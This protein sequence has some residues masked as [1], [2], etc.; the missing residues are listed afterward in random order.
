M[1]LRFVVGRAGSGKSAWVYG[2]IAAGLS[3][4]GRSVYLVVPEQYTLHTE[5][6]LMT[7]LGA[8]GLMQVRVV[9]P[10]RL[11]EEVFAQVR[12]E[13]AKEIGESGLAMALRA[14]AAAVAGD[15]QAYRAVL[16][17]HGFS[18]EMV[19]LIAECRRFD[20]GPDQIGAAAEHTRGALQAK[21]RDIALLYRQYDAFLQSHR[22]IDGESRFNSFIDNIAGAAFLAGCRFYFDGFDYLSAQNCRMVVALATVGESV[23]LVMDA[24]PAPGEDDELFQAAQRNM[25]RLTALVEPMGMVVER[26]A[27]DGSQRR[28]PMP[29]DV[30]HLEQNLFALRTEVQPR[31][32]DVQFCRANTVEEEVEAAACHVL[33][34]ARQQGLHWR[35]I[36]I[37]C[38]DHDAYAPVI[39]RVFARSHIPVFVD[40]RRQIARHPA[41][42]FLLGLLQVLERNYRPADVLRLWKAGFFPF[43]Q[44]TGETLELYLTAFG[45][46]GRRAWEREWTR[47]QDVFDLA[48]L[49]R[50]RQV[51]TDAVETVRQ[52]AGSGHPTGRKW[53][54]A[55]FALLDTMGID[56]LLDE[57]AT[58]LRDAGLLEEAAVTSHVWNSIVD[59]LDELCELLGSD[60]L[61]VEELADVLRSGFEAIEIGILPTGVDQVQVGSIGRSKYSG[62]QHLLLLGAC[63]GALSGVAEVRGPFT[64]RDIDELKSAGLEVGRDSDLRDAQRRFAVYQ[65]VTKGAR[66]LYVSWSRLGPD[67]AEVERDRLLV[68]MLELLDTKEEAVPLAADRIAATVD[69]NGFRHRLSALLAAQCAGKEPA[70]P[71]QASLLW[72]LREPAH[73]EDTERVLRLFRQEMAE[74]DTIPAAGVLFSAGSRISASQLET[75]GNCPFQHFVT[76]GLRPVPWREYGVPSTEVGNFLHQAMERFGQRMQAERINLADATEDEVR[77]AMGQEAVAL[78][79]EFQYGLL[80][81]SA[82]LRWTGG[83][84]RQIAEMAADT[85]RRQMA[86][87]QFRPFGQEVRFGRGGIPAAPLRLPNGSVVYLEGRVDRLDILPADGFEYFRVIDYKSSA[88]PLTVEDAVN[89]L[90]VQ[91]WLYAYALSTAWPRFRGTTGTAA[92]AYLFPLSHPWVNDD[93]EVDADQQMRAKLQLKGWCLDDSSV[94]QAMDSDLTDG[95]SSNL[96]NINFRAKKNTGVLPVEDASAVLGLVVENARQALTDMRVGRVA[97]YPWRDG[98][99]TACDRCEYRALCRIDVR[100]NRQFRPLLTQAEAQERV[101]QAKEGG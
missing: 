59:V 22:F 65:A 67:G 47:G 36:A 83:N 72:H 27:L 81:D 33:T 37:Q 87:G 35:E 28:T 76:H 77:A 79:Q 97:V 53:A 60:P 9:S 4:A 73:R 45:Q 96:Y 86:Q 34:L 41:V 3:P 98:K 82:R 51:V 55:L 12:Q 63:N 48:A 101:N 26:V 91:T 71:Q 68:R 21:A 69:A 88:R 52:A 29:P 99:E 75:F 20:I 80:N 89:G 11:A 18:L 56:A 44:R 39:A 92:A 50:C 64:S 49:N 78:Q 2:D 32:G 46:R 6:E 24:D 15:L 54:E 43:D 1:G 30:A 25:A 95:T 85:Y 62:L 40:S 84:L 57:Q 93:D 74:D 16:G 8:P 70:A 13:R 7:A 90:Q 10:T 38:G 17:Y 100:P 23:T 5:K 66:G 31:R 14:S 94:L 58:A 19:R 42:Q 61:T